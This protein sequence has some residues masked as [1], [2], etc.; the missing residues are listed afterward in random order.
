VLNSGQ[1]ITY[2]LTVGNSGGAASLPFVVND[3]L[4]AEVTFSGVSSCTAVFP[5]GI[6]VSTC[7]YDSTNRRLSWNISSLPAGS[8]GSVSFGV[9]VN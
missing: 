1:S 7:S 9:V 3:N 4:P 5:S 2:T 6:T 8:S